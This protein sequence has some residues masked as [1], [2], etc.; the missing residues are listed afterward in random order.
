MYPKQQNFECNS[1]EMPVSG[2]SISRG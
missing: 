2:D 1:M